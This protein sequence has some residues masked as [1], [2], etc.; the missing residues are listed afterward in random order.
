LSAH[1]ARLA[2]TGPLNYLALI[3]A[4]EL[5]PTLFEKMFAAAA[6]HA[7]LLDPDAPAVVR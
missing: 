4:I 2:D 7:G 6:V 1:A 3:D 5:L